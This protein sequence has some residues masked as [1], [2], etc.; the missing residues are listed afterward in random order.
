MTSSQASRMCVSCGRTIPFDV[1]VCPYCG[2]DYRYQSYQAQQPKISGGTKI[3]LYI[4][5]L[6][7]SI[8]GIIIGVVYLTKDDEDSKH[9]GKMCIILGIVSFALTIALSALLY[10]MVLGFGTA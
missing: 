9:V 2:H 1:N 5:S 4:V 6:L 8:V 3:A 10:I 7:F